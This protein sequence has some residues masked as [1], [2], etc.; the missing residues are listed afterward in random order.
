MLAASYDYYAGLYGYFANAGGANALSAPNGRWLVYQQDGTSNDRG[1]L[2]GKS[3]YGDGYNFTTNSFATT[4][5][6]GNRFVYAGQPTLTVTAANVT[7]PY[8][9]TVQ[10][11][12]YAVSGLING[13]A[14]A[15]SVAGV[16]TGLTTSSKNVDSYTLT[17]AGLTSPNGYLISYQPG[18]FIIGAGTLLYT[19]MPVSRTYGNANPAFTGTIT[20]FVNG[21]TQGTATTGTLS[22]ASAATPASGAGSYAITGTGLSATNYVFAQAPGNATALTIT[23]RALSVTADAKARVYG[24]TNPAL[25]YQVGGGGLINGDSLTGALAT[26]ATTTSNI[27]SFAITQGSLGSPNYQISYTGATLTVTPATLTYGATPAS[28][29]YGD[30]NP[31][32][33]GTV[34][35]FKLQDTQANATTGTL[36][37]TS[38]AGVTSPVGSYAIAGSGLSAANY[39][40]AQGAGNATAL[41]VLAR[42]ITVTADAL[43]RIYGDANPPLSYTVGGRGLVNGD[44]LT[45]MLATG[46][47]TPSNVGSYAI[48]QGSL[49]ASTN[50]ALTYTGSNLT[51]TPA[52]LTYT[53][54]AGTKVYGDTNPMFSGTVT[55]FKLQDTQA[56]ATTGT[57][58]FTSSAVAATPVGTRSIVGGGLA[59]TN[60][61]FVQAPGNATALS[62]TPAT[63]TYVAT[64]AS[65]VYGDANP[66]LGGTVTGFKVSDTLAGATTGTLAFASTADT[67]SSVGSYAVAG[68][69]LAASNYVFVQAAANASALSVLARPI[70]VT[71]DAQSRVYGDFNPVLTYQV[72]GRGLVNG[73][74]LAGVLATGATTTSSVGSYAIGQGSLTASP[75]YALTFTGNQLG[76]TVRPI[77][78]TADA[79]SRVYGDANPGL[80]YRIGGR[81]LVN[82]DTLTGALTTGAAATSGV[83][84]YAI[85]QGSLAA[86]TNYQLTYVGA[87]LAVTTRALSVTADTQSR[88]YGDANPLLTFAIGGRGLVNGDTLTGTL[89]TGADM[90]TGVGSY[91]ITQGSLTAGANYALTYTGAVLAVTPRPLTV[92]AVARAR[93]YGDLNPELA[94][95]TGGRGLVN[96]DQLTGSLATTATTTTGVGSYAITQGT[97]GAGGNYALTYVGA[98]LTVNA[99]PITISA[100]GQ[101]R[102]YGDANPALSYTLSGRTLV[103]G[104]MLTGALATGATVTSNVGSYA[105]NQGTL[106]ASA[107]YAVTY[108]AGT[109]LIDPAT[110]TYTAT[111]ASRAYGDANPAFGGSVA[112]FRNSDTQANATTG[113]LTFASPATTTSGVGSYAI[114]GSGLSA[115]NYVFDQASRNYGALTVT[116]RP[117]TITA[118]A[119]SRVY[120]NADPAL[121]YTVGGRGLV[122]TDTLTGTL[123][124]SA[125]T[126]S[127]VGQY[128]I[129]QGSL[130]AG[131]NY[132]LTYAG[133]NLTVTAR[134]ITVAADA[135]T[136]VYGDA[137]PALTYQLTSGML[138]NSDALTGVLATTAG[139]TT[140]IGGYAITQGSLTA[141]GNYTLTF[142]GANLTVTARPITVAADAKMRLY[143]DANPAL[144]Y[145]LT[146]GSLVNNDQLSGML[147]TTATQLSSVGSFAITQGTL[148]AT[149]NYAL[150]YAGASLG[151]TPATLTYTANAASR[152]Y[153]D[154]NPTL[155]GSV[156][157]FRNA[158]TQATSTGGALTFTTA[159]TTTTGVGMYAVNGSGL[160]ATNYL[161]VQ[162]A[163]NATA[164]TITPR[165]LTVAADAKNRVYRD[166]NPALTYQITT[167]S[168]INNDQLG[169]ALA[170]AA[171]LASNVGGY[172]ITQGTL[173]VGGNYA[174]TYQ[175]A[176]LTV[177]ARPISI[178]A[179]A[180]SRVYGDANPALTY[181]IGGRGLANG[182]TLS[183]V[184][185]TGAT[186]AS[187]VGG[188]AITQ[189][190]LAA[191]ANYAVAFTGATLSVTPRPISIAADAQTRIYGDANPTLSYQIGGRGLANGD[192]LT[193][194]L[195]AA[196]TARSDV[197]QYGIAQGSLAAGSNYALTFSGAQLTVTPRALT[198]TADAQRRAY[199][200]ANPALTYQ[201]AGL[202]NGDAL[203]GALTTDATVRSGVGAYAIAPGNVAVSANYTLTYVG[204][205]LTVTP[206]A[207]SVT[208]DALTRVYGDANPAL[209][210]R[211][212]GLVNG[213]MLAGGLATSAGLASGVGQYA[214]TQG[215]LANANYAIGYTGAAL[216]VAA[217]PLTVAADA[218]SRVY[219]DANPALT[220][221]LGGRGLANGDA[222]TGALSTAA[223]A[224]SNVG[225]YAIGQGNLAAGANYALT[226]TGGQLTVT[227]R[228]ITVTADAKTRI[229]GDANPTLSYAVAGRGL[230]NG[231][232]LTGALA[233]TATGA[234]GVGSYAIG[235]GS[236]AASSNYQF[237]YVAG[238]LVVTPRAITVTADAQNRVAGDPNPALTYRVGG[239]GLVNGDALSGALATAATTSSAVGLYPITQGSLAASGNYTVSYAPGTLTVT[240][241]ASSSTGSVAASGVFR[242]ALARLLTPF[243]PAPL[244]P[245]IGGA[246]GSYD[247]TPAEGCEGEQGCIAPR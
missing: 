25:T 244:A 197:G 138:V 175:G 22:F 166:A 69:G 235:Q 90:T 45:G 124:S 157:G 59:A 77:T 68:S 228:P 109:L 141:G 63:L 241:G 98:N 12:S 4:P 17:P 42:P 198:V 65:R 114:T 231:D 162:A 89:A 133:A 180:Q 199:G 203:S 178:T 215:T 110:L 135:K 79:L 23:P 136:R 155:A 106:A 67:A 153:G 9:G 243:P 116:A 121:T 189:G 56:N 5:L 217:R 40:F 194:A 144:T 212:A 113:A 49:A 53:A 159:A 161:F 48:T 18:T 128:L 47:T 104:D 43:S 220:Y 3:Q 193:G 234:S 55:G 126:T 122:N 74:T 30:A 96:N 82:E 236:L 80:T 1:G 34:T 66:V 149:A 123:A 99:R 246:V 179:D 130:D 88:V 163:G 33:T 16:A 78:V 207:L 95:I 73:D 26:T 120:G 165:A 209:T 132:A 170:T 14:S 156:T 119:K 137:N 102:I 213:D 224:T 108:R 50:Y 206:R 174:L 41:S 21:D 97:I 233:T 164:L 58:T 151:V 200:D 232:A 177:T 223:A 94:Y 192:A 171:T 219:G 86:T 147:A 112:G 38:A 31:A 142:Q 238:Q 222:L 6:A 8:S 70:N 11:D 201:A 92:T 186:P 205:Q 103:N 211:A 221:Q 20:G 115:T 173:G 15:D 28:R 145:Q 225:A 83:G 139:A 71:A 148:A 52:T 81:G 29:V 85:T 62:I 127:G 51:I 181:Q 190:S 247:E 76:V 131:F 57:L 118:D 229:Y 227:T 10:T 176:T 195:S 214:I 19:A 160:T 101:E 245:V 75:N 158:D 242:D 191:S 24:D 218:Q 105:I 64:P 60:Y 239:G 117:I 39:V 230:A 87:N 185:A 111:L 129:G 184:L 140:G 172:A 226:F 210:Y 167:G 146:S 187:A 107:N 46:A 35:G 7:S 240:P 143:G 54:N 27:G 2:V 93:V 61:L 84:S 154:A 13:D 196:A 37:F 32:L 36:A 202:V 169:G 183:G 152:T 44:T 100:D 208:A 150:T 168:L 125:T 182:D 72:G 204:A 188:F 91:A 216:T 237:T 134:P